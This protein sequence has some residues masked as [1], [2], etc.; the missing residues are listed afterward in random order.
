MIEDQLKQLIQESDAL[1]NQVQSEE[2]QEV[3]WIDRQSKLSD[4]E[5]LNILK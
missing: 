2:E 4:D 1:V 5:K 3:S